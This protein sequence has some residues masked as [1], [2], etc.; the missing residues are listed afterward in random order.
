MT[1]PDE[2]AGTPPTPVRHRRP[3]GR[4][5]HHRGG[6]HHARGPKTWRFSWLNLVIGLTFL[7]GLTLLIYPTAASWVSQ[8]NLSN[9]A[10]DQTLANSERA[11][12]DLDQQFADAHDFNSLLSSGAILSSGAN[13]AEGTG[14][15]STPNG[16]DY[17]SL[18]RGDPNGTLARLRVPSIDLD[19]PVYHGTSDRTLLM[20]VG[21]LQGTSL[22]VGGDGTRA[23]LT[24]HRGLANATMFTHLDRVTEG[25]VFSVEVLGEVLSYRVFDIQ[26]V[27]PDATEEIRAVPGKDLMTLVTCTPLGVN[28]HR[29]LLTGERVEPTPQGEID[30]MAAR[31]EVPRFPWWAIALAAGVASTGVWLWRSGLSRDGIPAPVP[32]R[33]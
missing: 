8:R 21:H 5:V 29:I 9:I 16:Y 10:H 1:V 31:P 14:T 22:P 20:G 18:L 30:G 32:A 2:T 6:R 15:G 27:A 12:A 7:A 4:H 24:G 13:V 19:L 17:W 3:G 28:T 25:D 23:V 11:K 33:E 26:V